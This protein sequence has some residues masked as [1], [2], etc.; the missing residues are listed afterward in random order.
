VPENVAS[1]GAD[2]I[3]YT[4]ALIESPSLF[5]RDGNGVAA[6]PAFEIKFLL[7]DGEARAVEDRIRLR[8][9]LDPHADLNLGGAYRTTS[10]YT[11]TPDFAVYR[12]I[13]EYGKSKYRVRRYGAGDSVFLERKDKSGD[14]VK[15]SRVP[16]PAGDLA[17]LAAPRNGQWAGDWFGVEIATR[18]LAPVCRIAYE[19]VAY[20]GNAETG[21]VRVTFDRRVRGEP[22]SGWEVRPVGEVGELL[23]GRVI[24]EFKYRLAMP[25]L[26]KEI[27]E[28]L[29]IHP[30]PCSKYR[31]F[32]AAAGIAPAN[33]A[34]NGGAADV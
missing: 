31:L 27:V 6:P 13:G 15:K 18:R 32:I 21:A 8:L 11:E 30:T 10:L 9:T 19:R 3:V 1:R 7:S 14:K 17:V 20:F 28:T 5:R 22:A 2:K 12:R 24:C 23:P 4:P 34:A 33:G 29:G 16:I 25:L 26:F